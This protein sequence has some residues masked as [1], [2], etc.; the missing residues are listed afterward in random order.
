MEFKVDSLK[1]R[2]EDFS[3]SFFYIKTTR[4]KQ[5]GHRVSVGGVEAVVHKKVHHCD[6][7]TRERTFNEL[8]TS[9]RT[10]KASK[11]GSN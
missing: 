1:F 8:I 6:L 4:S 9:D 11:E 2:V 5:C 10:R 3:L 7:R